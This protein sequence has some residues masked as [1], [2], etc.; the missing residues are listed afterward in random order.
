MPRK[1][2]SVE[3]EEALK[4]A[5]DLE[6]ENARLRNKPDDFD[7]S[8]NSYILVKSL[9]PYKLNLSTE[10][11]GKGRAFS[12]SKFGETKRVLYND[13]AS[14]FE[15]YRSFMEEGLFYIMD[16]RVI[17][18]HGLDDIYDH[19]LDEENILKVVNC[20]SNAAKLYEGA[21]KFQ[22]ETIDGMI[23]TELNLGNPNMDLNIISK[24]SKIANKDLIAEAESKKQLDAIPASAT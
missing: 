10:K 21:T 16:E 1:T 3:L 7:I 6:N 22:R 12:F 15:N 4:K 5:A 20:A 23:I 24:I 17:R 19:L 18:K 8:L 14:I 9:V 13:L 11:G 2:K